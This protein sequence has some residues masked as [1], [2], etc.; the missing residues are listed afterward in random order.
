M[1][2]SGQQH[3]P[4]GNCHSGKERRPKEKWAKPIGKEHRVVQG[5]RLAGVINPTDLHIE[6]LLSNTM[7]SFSFLRVRENVSS[8]VKETLPKE[9]FG[10]LTLPPFRDNF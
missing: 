1:S 6:L 2:V 9:N 8:P 7:R 10:L 4:G 3:D 5:L